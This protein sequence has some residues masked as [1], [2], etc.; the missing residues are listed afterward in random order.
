MIP[1]DVLDCNKQEMWAIRKR[2]ELLF[3]HYESFRPRFSYEN[4]SALFGRRRS[5]SVGFF[6]LSEK[7]DKIYWEFVIFVSPYTLLR[8][9]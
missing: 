3:H 5:S 4:P 1:A 9:V 6:I 7:L 2:Q 8:A